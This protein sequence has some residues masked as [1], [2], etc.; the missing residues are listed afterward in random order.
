MIVNVTD[1]VALG[2]PW[3]GERACLDD[4]CL[5]EIQ[6]NKWNIVSPTNRIDQDKGE[7]RS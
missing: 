3:G 6:Y 7:T 4:V 1:C 5:R 2:C